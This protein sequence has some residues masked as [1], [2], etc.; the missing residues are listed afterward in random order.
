[1]TIKNTIMATSALGLVLLLP[2]CL[3]DWWKKAEKA[4]TTQETAS[5]PKLR[6]IDVNPANIYANAHIEGA[7]NVPAEKI[8]EEAAHW[9]KQTP[10]VVYCGSFQC[11]TSHIVAKQLTELGFA[12]VKVFA[13]GIADWVRLAKADKAAHPLVGE[14]NLEFFSKEIPA[15]E[16][17]E[18]DISAE[19]FSELIKA[20]K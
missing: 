14:A 11:P 9:N 6:I 12:D 4:A 10:I 13:G 19:K 8:A 16:P 15:T 18:G 7:L 3:P 20:A 17:K 1:M 2:A 5:E